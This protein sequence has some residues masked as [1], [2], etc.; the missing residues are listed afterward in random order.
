MESKSPKL[1]NVN[2]AKAPYDINKFPKSFIMQFGR[3]MAYLMATRDTDSLEGPDWEQIFA[4]CIGAD[5]KPSNVGLDDV[6]LDNCCWGAKTVKAS[7]KNLKNQKTIRLIS[8]RNSPAYSYGEGEIL[9]VDP[10]HMGQMVLDIWNERVSSVR[11]KFKFVRTVILIKGKN[12]DEFCI[13]ETDTIRYDHELYEFKWN[14]NKNL[15]GYLKGT[16]THCFTW[17]PHGSQF[18]ICENIPKDKLLIRIKRPQKISKED[19][20]TAINYS[21]DWIEVL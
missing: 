1:R 5:W 17:Q 12:F 7:T 13:F 20:L 8:G 16:N 9:N 15:E 21:D 14:N 10:N 19:V 2:K 6:V 18:T 4:H 3:E 11:E